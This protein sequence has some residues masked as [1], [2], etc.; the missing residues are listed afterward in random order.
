M[1]GR[2]SESASKNAALLSKTACL[3][4][5]L[6]RRAHPGI[7]SA[8]NSLGQDFPHHAAIDISQTVVASGMPVD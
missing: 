7:I 5:M 8:R 6:A 4:I 1:Q 3:L 2:R